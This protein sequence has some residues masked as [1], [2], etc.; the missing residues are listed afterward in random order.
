M[1]RN[2]LGLIE[3]VGMTA[4]IVA[5]DTAVKSAN[6]RL[7]GYENSKGGGM[8]T[9]KFEGDVGAVKAALEAATVEAS[10]VNRIVSKH[11]IPRPSDEIEK[12]TIP[13]SRVSKEIITE[14]E[15]EEEE[16][17]KEEQMSTNEEE[18]R[19]AESPVEAV[20]E[21]QPVRKSVEQDE[22]GN[23][24][25]NVD[26]DSL[27]EEN[28]QEVCNICKDPMCTRRKGEARTMCIHY[29]ATIGGK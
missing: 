9:V 5:A 17:E 28:D 20:V 24:V 2:A 1:A 27:N 19:E 12:M 6:V 16:V 29:H 26:G 23:D 8:I 14:V 4:A 25:A 10:K 7:I 18:V 21:E 11:F 13:R 22:H 3:V 15:K